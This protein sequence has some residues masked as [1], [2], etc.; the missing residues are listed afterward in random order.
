MVSP[1]ESPGPRGVAFLACGFD[2]AD[3]VNGRSRRLAEG[4]AARGVPVVYVTTSPSRERRPLREERGRLTLFRVPVLAPVDWATSLGVLEVTAL[5]VL[6]R[7]RDDLDAIYAA[8]A[9]V[10]GIAA[11]VGASVGLPVAVGLARGGR[12]GDAW[13][14]LASP[15]RDRALAALRRVDRVVAP[16]DQTAAEAR[17]LLGVAPG[18][19]LQVADGVDLR[20]HR[21]R[22]RPD[23]GAAG[24]PRLLVLGRL[25]PAERVDVLL[26]ACVRL[27]DALGDLEL[28]VAGSG[29]LRRALEAEAVEL[30]LSRRVRFVGRRGDDRPLL[31]S[32][33]ALA[34]PSEID[35]AS[36]VLLAA[37]ATAVPIV[38]TAVAGTPE[39]VRDGVE[40]L[41]VPPGDPAAL[42]DALQRVVAAPALARRLGEAGR[43]RAEERHDLEAVV[44]RHV[45]LLGDLRRAARAPGSARRLLRAGARAGLRTGRDGVRSSVTRAVDGVRRRVAPEGP[46]PRGVAVLLRDIDVRGPTEEQALRLVDRLAAAGHRVIVLS[47]T[48]GLAGRPD[49]AWVEA[50]RGG[51]TVYRVPLV[52]F[53]SIGATLLY[54]HRAEWSAVYA[55]QLDMVVIGARLGEV[56]GAPVAVKLDRGGPHGDVATIGSLPPTERERVLAALGA[57]HLVCQSDEIAAEARSLGLAPERLVRIPNGVDVDAVAAAPAVRPTRGEPT[58]LFRGALTHAKGVD[59][60]LHAFAEAS[61]GAPLAELLLA[62]AG[63][64]ADELRHLADRLG[65]AG[66]VHFLGRRE[67]GWGLVRGATVFALP[68]RSEGLSSSLLEALAAGTPVVASAIPPNA[69][70]LAGGAG[71]LVPPDDVDAFAH[72]LG[73][74]LRQPDLRA[75]LAARGR[76]R[77]REAFSLQRTV[78]AYSALFARLGDEADP[79]GRL[80]F[81]GRFLGARGRDVGRVVRKIWS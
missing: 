17:D 11:R 7:R 43:R 77:V 13:A 78:E 3:G 14:A 72:A 34:V 71:V 58:V 26:Q 79:P 36:D 66:R 50:D 31:R 80:R 9:D 63:P 8:P 22:P 15:E 56:L 48:P 10:G 28:T 57:C 38:A 39:R 32:A 29:P 53:E 74:L 65:V 27:R 19:I 51:V 41:L 35:A 6:G 69:E 2:R 5:A 25:G 60:L 61:E 49:G 1:P 20:R 44:D 67:D 47:C 12:F 75:R 37:M 64:Q 30:G 70:V 21:P 73:E 42:A 4:I 18:R 55:L 40:A 76:A 59:L 62:G 46:P 24:P 81:A 45:E 16:T 52:A 68:S 33:T 23:D 54:R